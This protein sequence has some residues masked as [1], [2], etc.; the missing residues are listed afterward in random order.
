MTACGHLSEKDT[1]AWGGK[2]LVL[3]DAC[4]SGT[5]HVSVKSAT[6]PDIADVRA[7]LTADGNSVIVLSSSTGTMSYPG[8]V[9]R[10]TPPSRPNP[11]LES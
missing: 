10:L 11:K 2:I 1:R 8:L 5:V 3:L 7:D 9:R 6:P 4:H